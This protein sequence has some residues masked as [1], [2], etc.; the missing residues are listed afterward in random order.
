MLRNIALAGLFAFLT[1]CEKKN[2]GDVLPE[3]PPPEAKPA[4]TTEP[5]YRPGYVLGGKSVNAGTAFVVKGESG[6]LLALT[7]AHVLD[8]NEWGTVQSASLNKMAGS[9]VIELPGKPASVGRSFGELPPIENG[10]FPLFNTS[11]DLVIWVL[12]EK[13]AIVPLEMADHEPSVNEWVWVVGQEA[14][15]QLQFYRAKVTRVKDGT[16]VMKQHD[17]CNPHGFSGGAVLNQAGKVIGNMLAADPKGDL[18]EGATVGT[19]RKRIAGY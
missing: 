14:G 1:G 5:A 10:A 13:T 19:I 18:M 4:L 12:P 8:A 15:K 17:R 3:T 2:D 16:F 11:E 9:R 6:K 7:A